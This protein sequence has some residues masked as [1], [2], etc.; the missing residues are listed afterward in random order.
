ME[1]AANLALRTF[2]GAIAAETP[3]AATAPAPQQYAVLHLR[4]SPC[5]PAIPQTSSAIGRI[6]SELNPVALGP[7]TP[8]CGHVPGDW[9]KHCRRLS[10]A[11]DD[12]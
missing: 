1:R 4:M 11:Q 2:L 12:A 6:R 9:Q 8:T 7:V 3:S 10:R 5:T